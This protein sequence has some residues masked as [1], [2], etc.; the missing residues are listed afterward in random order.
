MIRRHC[1]QV[2]ASFLLLCV[3]VG[4][5]CTL[6][7]GVFWHPDEGAKFLAMRSLRW[8]HGIAYDVP[9]RGRGIDPQLRFYAGRCGYGVIYPTADGPAGAKN[10][11]PI[12]FPLL[13]RPLFDLFGFSGL[14][15]LPLLAGWL[16]AVV[17]GRWVAGYDERLSGVATL[18]VG[19]SSPIIFYSVSFSEH[20][21]A[22]LCGVIAVSLLLDGRTGAGRLCLIGMCLVLASVLRFEMLGFAAAV[23]GTLAVSALAARRRASTAGSSEPT[24]RWPTWR[25]LVATIGVTFA[26]G[27]VLLNALAPRHLDQFVAVPHLVE[28]LRT[29]LPFL[30]ESIGKILMGEPGFHNALA[31][32][33]WLLAM[34]LSIGAATVAPFAATRRGE[35]ML[36][37]G[38]LGVLLASS[39][40]ATLWQEAYLTRQGVLA[41]APYMSVSSYVLAEAW[42]RHD[43]RLFRLACVTM[44]YAAIGCGAVFAAKVNDVGEYLIGLDGPARYLLTLYPMGAVLS[45]LAV[46]LYWGS[47][48]HTVLKSAFTVLVASMVVAATVYEYRGLKMVSTSRRTLTTWETA[49]QAHDRVITNVWWLAGMLA[50]FSA[51]REFYCVDELNAVSDWAGL[52]AAHGVTAFS[53]ASVNPIDAARFGGNAG[54]IVLEESEIVD[55]L[56]LN[57]YRLALNPGGS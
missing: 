21:L 23:V 4:G 3:A 32:E 8:E 55:G 44:C 39:L 53:F 46:A 19:C 45:L 20:T 16:T 34:V 26:M 38:A 5:L 35:A 18:L 27:A 57:H 47:E 7:S 22:T 2:I 31:D 48:R 33:T 41:V 24:L 42:T 14:Y 51:T 9:Y 25:Q 40:R 49:L 12:A 37:V 56:Y 17:A 43:D 15:L 13:S 11:W 29:K 10:Y 52:A 30:M 1:G 54:Q 28:H 50:P 6:P 36:I